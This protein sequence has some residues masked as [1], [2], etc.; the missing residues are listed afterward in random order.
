V[1]TSAVSTASPCMSI[2]G[3]IA[4]GGENDCENEFKAYLNYPK[5]LMTSWSNGRGLLYK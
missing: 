3:S 1:H 4:R 5:Q 2:S